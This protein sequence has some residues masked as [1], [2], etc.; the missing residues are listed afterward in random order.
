MFTVCTEN[1]LTL[2]IS[3][4][5]SIGIK[6][7]KLWLNSII[8]KY[9]QSNF[10]ALHAK[11]IEFTSKCNNVCNKMK[12]LLLLNAMIF[13]IK[14][15]VDRP[16]MQKKNQKTFLYCRELSYYCHN[17][18]LYTCLLQGT[19]VLKSHI[20]RVQMYSKHYEHYSRKSNF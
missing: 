18:N 20:L 19:I 1:F 7:N 12:Y 14:C 8:C 6:C 13:A 16:K 4:L 5:L 9:K 15:T 11:I 3:F 10:C 2:F 17:N